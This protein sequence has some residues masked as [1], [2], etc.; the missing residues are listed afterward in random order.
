[1]VV[2]PFS[3]TPARPGKHALLIV[4]ESGDDKAVT[5]DLPAGAQVGWMDL[6]PFDNNLAVR[7][8]RVTPA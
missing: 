8:V 6:V 3:W 7:E 1:V 2:G 5:Q 4:V